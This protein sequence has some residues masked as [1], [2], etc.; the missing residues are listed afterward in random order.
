MTT[1]H[2][3]PTGLFLGELTSK[4]KENG[5]STT[6]AFLLINRKIFESTEYLDGFGYAKWAQS[7]VCGKKLG[8]T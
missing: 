5:V 7:K 8:Q 4:G 1:E 3:V 6:I 2:R